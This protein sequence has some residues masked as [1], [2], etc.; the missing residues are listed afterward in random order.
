MAY[1]CCRSNCAKR[2]DVVYVAACHIDLAL[3]VDCSGSIRKANEPGEDNWEYVIEFM[4]DIVY[5]VNVADD[6]THVAAVSFGKQLY[7]TD[8]ENEEECPHLYRTTTLP[9]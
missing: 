2:H 9:I 8:A 4:V 6:K 7:T 1:G 5:S 3:V